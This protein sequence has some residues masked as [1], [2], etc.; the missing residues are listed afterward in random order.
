MSYHLS[1]L[2]YYLSIIRLFSIYSLYIY[3]YIAKKIPSEHKN[4]NQ[5][6]LLL[7]SNS[8]FLSY[9]GRNS[10]SNSNF[11]MQQLHQYRSFIDEKC[12]KNLLLLTLTFIT[13]TV[14]KKTLEGLNNK[15]RKLSFVTQLYCFLYVSLSIFI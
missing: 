12:F 9:S 15:Q 3:S 6:T 4:F 2:A 1:I 10:N 14:E 8:Y 11:A 5:S 7:L 13:I